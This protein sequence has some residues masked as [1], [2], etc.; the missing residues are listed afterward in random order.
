MPAELGGVFFYMNSVHLNDSTMMLWV[1]YN[2]PKKDCEKYQFSIEVVDWKRAPKAIALSATKF[3]V[4]C[5]MS[6]AVVKEK[7]L[8]V[9]I[10]KDL[11]KAVDIGDVTGN[12]P[13]SPTFK[14]NVQFFLTRKWPAD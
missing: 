10:G 1:S 8:G 13:N 6:L 7:Y 14:T 2:G 3:C 9:I 4:P 12:N 5:D 11:A